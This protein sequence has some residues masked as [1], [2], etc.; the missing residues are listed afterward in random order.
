MGALYWR[1]PTESE[2]MQLGLKA[3]HFPPPQVEL[4]PECV[5][6]IE[7]FSRVSTQWR[8]GAGGPI[9]LDYNVVY[10]ELQ[11]EALV[12]ERHA[13]VMAGIRVIEHAALKHMQHE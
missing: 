4:W 9:G 1:A 6:P 3:K 12:P 5:L 10:Q 8:V 7:V 11:R 2:L 13:E